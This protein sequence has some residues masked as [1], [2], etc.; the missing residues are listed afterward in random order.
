MRM[1]NLNRPGK[2]PRGITEQDV[3]AAADALLLEG[4]RPTIERVRMQI[5]RG[6]PNTVSPHLE[7][8][9]ARLGS[10]IADPQAFSAPPDVPEPVLQAAR[11]FWESAL[12]LA[13]GEAD[14]R[15]RAA[16]AE[17]DA[18]V[19]EALSLRSRADTAEATLQALRLAQAGAEA[20]HAERAEASQREVDRLV[21]EQAALAARVAAQDEAH[22][23]D[24]AAAVERA[25]QAERRAAADMDR[26]RQARARAEQ[27][28]RETRQQSDQALTDER[29]RAQAELVAQV[30]SYSRLEAQA[31]VLRDRVGQV[32]AEMRRV[33]LRDRSD[34][35]RA[36]ASPL[37]RLRERGRG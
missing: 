29:S 13:R 25:V 21:G 31:Q 20:A 12:A 28:A 30:Q 17:R 24:L 35:T 5:G 10:R 36:G 7:S 11:H 14:V 34:K 6:S 3:W 16:E 23:A 22:R 15:A 9:F 32:E 19:L 33:R 27:L 37:A 1:A 2:T 4:A 26:E 8:W 18:A